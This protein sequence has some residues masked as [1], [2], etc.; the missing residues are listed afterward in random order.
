MIKLRRKKL[1]GFGKEN[2]QARMN[3][4]AQIKQPTSAYSGE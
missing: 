1:G 3:S 4:E 2:K